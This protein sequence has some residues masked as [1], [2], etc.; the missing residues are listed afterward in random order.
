MREGDESASR[1]HGERLSVCIRAVDRTP[2]GEHSLSIP[3]LFR[4][5]HYIVSQSYMVHANEAET[6]QLASCYA[7]RDRNR[8]SCRLPECLGRGP[9][10]HR[11]R[12]KTGG[13]QPAIAG[14]GS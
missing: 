14:C 7:Q 5:Y 12:L 8:T 13:A 6:N 2:F 1:C 9:Q 4:Q 10:R 11:D 3:M